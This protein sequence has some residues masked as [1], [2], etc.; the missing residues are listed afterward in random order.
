M[1]DILFIIEGSLLSIFL[2]FQWMIDLS[3]RKESVVDIFVIPMDGRLVIMDGSMLSGF[4]LL[5]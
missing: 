3:L 4:L 1:D 2:L 5:Q